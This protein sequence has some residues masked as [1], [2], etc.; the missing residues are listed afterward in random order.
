ML[1]MILYG[2]QLICLLAGFGLAIAVQQQSQQSSGESSI[3]VAG[4]GCE[5]MWIKSI[6]TSNSPRCNCTKVSVTCINLQ[7]RPK[8]Q[9]PSEDTDELFLQL[10]DRRFEFLEEVTVIGNNL[11]NLRGYIFGRSVEHENLRKLNISANYFMHVDPE[12]FKGIPNLEILDLS[13]NKLVFDENSTRVFEPIARLRQLHLESTFSYRQPKLPE[14]LT[15]AFKRARLNSLEILNLENNHLQRIP[16][17]L[18]CYLPNLKKLFYAQNP[19]QEWPQN[20]NAACGA[21]QSAPN[22]RPFEALQLLDISQ[23][24]TTHLNFTFIQFVNELPRTTQ[25]RLSNSYLY[26]NCHLAPFISWL[27]QTQKVIAKDEI[28]CM[29]AAP[30]KYEGRPVLSVN[31]D[32]LE[33]EISGSISIYALR[34]SQ[35]IPLLFV[36]IVSF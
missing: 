17:E 15:E 7:L 21:L 5:R 11:E 29:E 25:I 32:E 2:H 3:P 24:F 20:L 14:Y 35:L 18:G 16:A 1:K 22:R 36:M 26:C 12:A 31:P 4:S 10:E 8:P 19:I 6:D 27:N 13:N 28:V 23:T 30:K 33:C 34:M 9:L